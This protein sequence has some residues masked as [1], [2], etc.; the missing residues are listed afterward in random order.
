MVRKGKIQLNLHDGK[1]ILT[2][3]KVK[4][5]DSLVLELPKIKIK[6]VLE[7]KKGVQI[8]L[9]KGKYVGSQGTLL[10]IQGNKII[11]QKDKEKVE[12]LK[13]YALV[14]GEKEPLIKIENGN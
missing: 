4:V 6:Q 2:E 10:E 9:L 14:I 13:G 3:E 12:T 1:N 7:F 5:G 11:Y 8:F